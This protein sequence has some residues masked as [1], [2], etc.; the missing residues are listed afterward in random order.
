MIHLAVLVCVSTL[1]VGVLGAIALRRLSAVRAQLAAFELL[2][3]LLPLAAVLLSG[4]V[5]FHMG[6]Y[7]KILAVAA[8]AAASVVAVA[9]VLAAAITRP[10]EQLSA[11]RASPLLLLRTISANSS[12]G[13]ESAWKRTEP[14]SQRVFQPPG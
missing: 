11:G 3:A 10:L 12:A 6:A 4:W 13:I 7:V 1:V 9:L 14:S 5:M 8:A 2:A